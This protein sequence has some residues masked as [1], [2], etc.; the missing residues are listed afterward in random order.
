[1]ILGK[2]INNELSLYV[3]KTIIERRH[4]VVLLEITFG[5]ECNF[6]KYIE[7]IW[8]VATYNLSRHVGVSE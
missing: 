4:E 1:M 7:N 3:K 5:E 8:H 2:K 6:K